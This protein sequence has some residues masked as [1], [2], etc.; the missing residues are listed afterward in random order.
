MEVPLSV[1]CNILYMGTTQ[2]HATVVAVRAR[3][4]GG[5]LCIS[6]QKL[7]DPR[8]YVLVQNVLH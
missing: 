8:S 5:H 1:I 2:V 4:G 6:P 7:S 3:L